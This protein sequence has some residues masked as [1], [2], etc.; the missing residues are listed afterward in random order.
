MIAK[1]SAAGTKNFLRSRGSK[2]N[3]GGF[4]NKY[5]EVEDTADI[6][7][8]RILKNLRL[9]SESVRRAESYT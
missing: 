5:T 3:K 2:K 8:D 1:L 9:R 4:Y 7:I 6:E